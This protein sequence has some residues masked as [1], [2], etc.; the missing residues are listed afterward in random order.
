MLKPIYYDIGD[1]DA[2]SPTIIPRSEPEKYSSNWNNANVYILS[3]ASLFKGF[4]EL[5]AVPGAF[6]KFGFNFEYS[7]QDKIIHALEVGA[8]AEGFSKKIEIMDF[9]NAN[10][11][12]TKI[13]KNQQFVLTLFVCYRFGRIVDP[14]EVKK[15]RQHTQEISY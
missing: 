9:T 7:K 5:G 6:V 15:K 12:Q 13:A 2:S 3:R 8:F 1:A 14:Y 10:I 11:S 4:D